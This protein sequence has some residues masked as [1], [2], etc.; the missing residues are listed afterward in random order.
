MSVCRET[1]VKLCPI[2]ARV[3]QKPTVRHASNAVSYFSGEYQTTPGKQ[4]TQGLLSSHL[5][6]WATGA[7]SF[8]E[9]GI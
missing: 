2:S 3:S 4:Q 7:Y 6:T 5:A 9:S 1:T 8:K